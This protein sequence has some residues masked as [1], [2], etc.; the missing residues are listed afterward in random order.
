M[1]DLSSQVGAVLKSHGMMLASAESCTG[2]GIAQ[3]VTSVSGSSAW[4][5]RGFVT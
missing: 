1:H 2:G 3:A 5:E 4:F